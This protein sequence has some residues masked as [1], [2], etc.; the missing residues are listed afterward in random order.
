MSL[1][2]ALKRIKPQHKMAC[3]IAIMKVIS[4]HESASTDQ[5]ASYAEVGVDQGG[6]QNYATL[7]SMYVPTEDSFAMCFADNYTQL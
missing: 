4:D 7:Q 1:A 2:P 3:K 6:W 5:R